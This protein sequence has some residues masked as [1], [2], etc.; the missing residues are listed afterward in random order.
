MRQ[1][2]KWGWINIGQAGG[3]FAAATGITAFYAATAELTNEVYRRVSSQIRL[4]SPFT[5]T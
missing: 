2:T 5:V 3:Y 1:S 4:I